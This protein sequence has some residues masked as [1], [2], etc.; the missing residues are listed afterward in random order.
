MNG[1]PAMSRVLVEIVFRYRLNY[2]EVSD[3]CKQQRSKSIPVLA[4]LA[5][6]R[7]GIAVACFVLIL[8]GRKPVAYQDV[9]DELEGNRK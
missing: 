2:S 4:S 3:S 6:R 5:A 7:R 1:R 9:F 8:R